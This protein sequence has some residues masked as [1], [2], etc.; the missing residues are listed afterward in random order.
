MRVLTRVNQALRNVGKYVCGIAIL[1]MMAI[2]VV[3]VFMRNVIGISLS[4]GYDI[5]ESFLMPIATF[6]ALSY[7]YWC[8]VLP[9]LTELASK[10][11]N[12][13]EQL[14]KI[15]ILFIDMVVFALM[16]S[17]GFLFALTGMTEEVAVSIAGELVPIWPVY[18][19]VPIG[20]FLVFAEA[21]RKLF[22]NLSEI[23][24]NKTVIQ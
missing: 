4:G 1:M 9:K 8:G 11:P 23:S 13:F 2:T 3:D 17:F 20:F 19:I 18:F 6:S 12:W 14:N 10:V 21:V 22:F 7:V 15:V 16:T 24:E 5:I